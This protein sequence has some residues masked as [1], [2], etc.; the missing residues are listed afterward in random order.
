VFWAYAAAA[1][2]HDRSEACSADAMV[3]FGAA[4]A[5]PPS[6]ALVGGL[7]GSG[8]TAAHLADG[9]D[10]ALA[11]I[12]GTLLA[13]LDRRTGDFDLVGGAAGIA[14]YFL[15]REHDDGVDRAV[16]AIEA[17]CTRDASGAWWRSPDGRVD[18]GLAHGAA[19]VAAVLAKI[20]ARGHERAAALRDDAVRWLLAQRLAD[21]RFP[22]FAGAGPSRTAW[23]YGEPGIALALWHAGHRDDPVLRAWLAREPVGIRDACLCHGAAGLAHVA[24]RLYHATGDDA[25]RAF[26]RR[27]FERTLDLHELGRGIGG[28]TMQN[29]EPLATPKL[30]DGTAGVGLALFAALTDMEPVW[31]APMLCDLGYPGR[32]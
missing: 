18:C 5:A 3:R 9:V 27:W 15:A 16:A 10:D 24:N 17:A 4:L 31:D 6:P 13:W 1:L 11:A 21:D 2:A 7:A 22:G 14:I 29:A 26:A 28:F 25:Y 20:A 12:D 32:T 23:C 19:G 30:V 8:W